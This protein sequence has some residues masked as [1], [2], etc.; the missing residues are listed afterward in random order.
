MAMGQHI[1]NP[2]EWGWDHLKL[3]GSA[4]GS[5]AHALDEALEVRDSAPPEVR[6]IALADIREALAKGFADFG[7]FRTDV[8]FLCLIYPIAGLVLSRLAF[9]HDM[10]PLIFPLAS[11]FALIGPVVA[12]G[13]YEMSRR[14]ERGVETNWA[15]AFGV[16]RSPAFGAMLM[17]GL[18][19]L[20]IFGVWQ[21]AA[22]A[23]YDL[24]L[25][26]AMPASL[27]TFVRDVLTTA[28]GWTM[29]AAGIG[30]G[31]VFAAVVLTIS[32]IS[33]PLLLDR[34]VGVSTAVTT[35]IR[36]VS[37]NPGPM[38][39]WGLIVAASLV[40][41]AIPLLLGYAIVIPVL[42]HATWHLYRK[43]VPR[44]AA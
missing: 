42:G 6:R 2:I 33:F 39:A 38:A 31:F 22:W 35:S 12:V 40:L 23:I 14:H 24:T 21:V 8:I 41:G 37:A 28:P 30:V 43:V 5:A 27:E 16:V 44:R 25:G 3:T 9:G 29:I 17:L 1:R 34:D 11:G 26:P 13:L 15:S 19:L 4:V 7:A 20:A 10:L 36:A 18:L 32:V